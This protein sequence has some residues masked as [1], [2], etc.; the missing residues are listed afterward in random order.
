MATARKAADKPAKNTAAKA[1][2]FV[3]PKKLAKVA[4]LLYTTRQRRLEI[5]KQVDILAKQETAL[6]N[7]LIDNLPK[8]EASGVS[9]EVANAKV[10]KKTVWQIGDWG[11]F[12]KYIQKTGEFD[13]LGR[14]VSQPALQERYEAAKNKMKIPGVVPFEAIKVSCTKV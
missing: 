13:L 8:S 10:E 14:S 2:K 7:H 11:K 4:D 9:G 5:Q 3:I 1:A 6:R 12:Q